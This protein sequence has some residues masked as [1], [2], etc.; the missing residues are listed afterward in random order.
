MDYVNAPA[1]QLVATNC[2]VCA[3]PLLDA[4]SVEAGIG[5][6]CREKYGFNIDAAPEAR[7]EA[8][9]LVHQLA[10]GTVHSHAAILRLVQLGFVK[11]AT[12]LADGL[13][14]VRISYTTRFDFDG[15]AIQTPFDGAAVD[16]FRAIPGRRFDHEV[17]AWVVPVAQREAVWTLLRR[18]FPRRLGH[19]P[20]GY[21][22]VEP[23]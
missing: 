19:G 14:S 11:L 17:K 12:K 20:K 23:L 6:V 3:R 10:A 8:N 15:F 21:F 13:V 9:T 18:H 16:D 7:A 1:T 5:P 2:C 4:V 22:A